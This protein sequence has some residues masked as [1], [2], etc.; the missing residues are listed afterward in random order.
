MRTLVSTGH[1]LAANE[2]LRRTLSKSQSDIIP[3]RAVTFIDARKRFEDSPL[4]STRKPDEELED[5]EQ[6]MKA[7]DFVLNK[8]KNDFEYIRR[9]T[10]KVRESLV[11]LR[12]EKK[13]KL[14]QE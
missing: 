12:H 9:N 14:Y 3:K 8:M 7:I 5:L 4:P 1:F 2:S 10:D 6:E 11:S 13:S